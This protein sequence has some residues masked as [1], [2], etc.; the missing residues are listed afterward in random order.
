MKKIKEEQ[1]L[2]GVTGVEAAPPIVHEF[3]CACGKVC[4]KIEWPAGT[5]VDLDKVKAEHSTVCDDC[6]KK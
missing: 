2:S 1:K 4:G 6:A 3:K 5:E